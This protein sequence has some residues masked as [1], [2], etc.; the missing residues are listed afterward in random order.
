[1][2]AV[3]RP[4]GAASIRK[5]RDAPPRKQTQCLSRLAQWTTWEH[6]FHR[7]KKKNP[8]GVATCSICAHAACGK[9]VVNS[10]EVRSA[11]GRGV[12]VSRFWELRRM[13]AG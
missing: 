11:A 9:C 5:S 12:G 13:D 6:L 3:L 7:K 1:M 4:Y 10:V 8:P 2:V